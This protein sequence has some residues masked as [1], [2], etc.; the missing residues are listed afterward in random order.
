MGSNKITKAT[1]KHVLY[2]GARV[3]RILL[4]NDSWFEKMVEILNIP[5]DSDEENKLCYQDDN[6][7]KT[8]LPVIKIRIILKLIHENFLIIYLDTE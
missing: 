1:L 4:I 6:K 3:N 2:E 8:H 7:N 5:L